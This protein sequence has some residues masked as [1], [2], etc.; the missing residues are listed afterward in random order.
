MKAK[1]ILIS[2][3]MLAATQ[4][5][6]AVITFGG[7]TP[8]DGSQQTSNFVPSSAWITPGGASSGGAVTNIINPNSGF[9]IET[10]DRATQNPLLPPGVYSDSLSIPDWLEIQSAGCGVNSAGALSVSGSGGIGVQQGNTPQAAHDNANTTCFGYAP[11][12]NV[13]PANASMVVDYTGFIAQQRPGDYIGYL[14]IYYGSID[15]YNALE[16]G[17]IVNNVFVPINFQLGNNVF[18]I[19]TGTTILDIFQLQSGNRDN[20]NRYVNIVFNQN[21]NFTAFRMTNTSSRAFEIDN[22]VV[23][24]NS[25]VTVPAPASIGILGLGLVGLLLNRRRQKS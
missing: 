9:Y 20:S 10:F 22:I 23:G 21:E 7:Q 16:F 17:N 24:L 18:N 2:L 19:L 4:A 1:L 11:H 8:I 25:A 12:Y 3:S 13:N 5:T 15:T 6:A 14:G